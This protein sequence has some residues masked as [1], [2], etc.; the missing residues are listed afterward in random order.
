MSALSF[1]RPILDSLNEGKVI[2]S[3]I[4]NSLK[5]LSILSVVGGIYLLV[6]VLKVS[7]QFPTEG[8]I[9]GIIFSAI[10]LASIIT[11]AQI[12]LYRAT[13]IAQI[14]ESPFTV[15]PVC[16]ILVRAFGEVYS[17]LGLGIGMGGCIFIWLSKDN[18]L[19]YVGDLSKMFPSMIP[20]MSLLGGILF[21]AY[22]ALMSFIVFV[23]SY[24]LGEA[25]M[26]LSDAARNGHRTLRQSSGIA[27]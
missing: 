2:R 19:Y 12:L 13:S 23:V 26:L 3:T 21:L 16:S 9:G 20:E 1:F 11:V 5:I 10:L 18:P 17:T 14:H 25:I 4:V 6:D 24:F 27:R 22:S 7:F 15:L 8:T